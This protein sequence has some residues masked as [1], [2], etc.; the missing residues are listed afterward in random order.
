MPQLNIEYS[1]DLFDADR[2]R[3]LALD[4]HHW[5]APMVDDV[6]SFKTR[7][8]P[9]V[10]A[11]IGDGDPRH[12]M[13]HVELGVL[14][15]RDA[16]LRGRLAD[17]TLDCALDCARRATASLAAERDVQV[18]VEVREMARGDYRKAVI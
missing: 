10:G 6:A 1:A 18:T 2:M 11:V 17:F 7:L 13:L 16:A 12:A 15:G 14:S 5:L 3:A 9:L 4:L 8:T